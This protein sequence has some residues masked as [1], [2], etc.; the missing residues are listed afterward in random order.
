MFS[1][2]ARRIVSGLPVLRIN[3]SSSS[4]LTSSAFAAT[5]RTFFTT[6]RIQLPVAAS[7][8]ASTAVKKTK[9]K[10][11]PKK[12]KPTTKAKSKP[13]SR[14]TP[15]EKI[16]P[17]RPKMVPKSQRPPSRPPNAYLLFFS[18]LV[19]GQK[20]NIKST[21]DTQAVAQQAAAAW[22]GFTLA[23]KQPFY[24][25]VEVL[26]KQ[27]EERLHDYWKTTPPQ[28]VRKINARRKADGKK[29]IHRPRQEG[30]HTRPMGAFFRF[31]GNFRQSDDGRAIQEAGAT[32]TGRGAVNVAREAGK[33]WR[34]MSASDKAPYMEASQK[35]HADWQANKSASASES[36]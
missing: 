2:F 7:K 12:A 11:A 13:K 36:S 29:K 20:D 6:R 32:I 30:D 15:K 16:E 1:L 9:T 33:R 3:V 35:A 18:R 24:D 26:K 8:S 22:K 14:A 17:P 21:T 10:A 31:I 28:I 19:Q 25:E 4:A 27:Y 5:R 23:E 34:A